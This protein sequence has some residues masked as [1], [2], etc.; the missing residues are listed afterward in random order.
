MEDR[1]L[2]YV[3]LY[4]NLNYS[5]A[6]ISERDE[7]IYVFLYQNLNTDGRTWHLQITK[8]YVFLYQNLNGKICK[9][10]NAMLKFMYFYIRI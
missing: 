6:I 4:Q 2:I 10:N 9:T 5:G 1:T 8:I 7:T 3:F